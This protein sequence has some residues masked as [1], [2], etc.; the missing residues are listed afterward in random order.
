MIRSSRTLKE[1]LIRALNFSDPADKA[2]HGKMV[3]LVAVLELHNRQAASAMRSEQKPHQRQFFSLRGC[4]RYAGH[5][6]INL[7]N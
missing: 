3:Q 5:T 2:R 6:L 1:F 4:K 7:P